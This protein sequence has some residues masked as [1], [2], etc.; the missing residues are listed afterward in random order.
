MCIINQGAETSKQQNPEE[1]FPIRGIRLHAN[2]WFCCISTTGDRIWNIHVTLVW[3]H[4][5]RQTCVACCRNTKK[6]QLIFTSHQKILINHITKSSSFQN[7]RI[8]SYWSTESNIF[9]WKTKGGIVTSCVWM[10]FTTA[11]NYFQPN[12]ELIIKNTPAT[13]YLLCYCEPLL[14]KLFSY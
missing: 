4:P 7:I 14:S 5:L 3:K 1:L 10:W 2:A 11:K 12:Q 9:Q 13:K 6:L 8:S